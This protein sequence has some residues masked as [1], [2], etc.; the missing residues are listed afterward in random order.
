[1]PACDLCGGRTALGVGFNRRTLYLCIDHLR[2]FRRAQHKAIDSG[3][4]PT[5]AELHVARRVL[6]A[7]GK[8]EDRP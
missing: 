3:M 7:I 5:D 6:V 2:R 1:M 8:W 4:H